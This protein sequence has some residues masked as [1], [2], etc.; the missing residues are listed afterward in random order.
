LLDG[1]DMNG[2]AVPDEKSV[3]TQVLQ[4]MNLLGQQNQQE[5]L[6][7]QL[8]KR[9][10]DSLNSKKKAEEIKRRSDDLIKWINK[11]N[12]EM[13]DRPEDIHPDDLQKKKEYKD[14]HFDHVRKPKSDEYNAIVSDAMKLRQENA[15][16]NLS[17]P[18]TGVSTLTAAWKGLMHT[19]SA[20]I[21]YIEAKLKAYQLV[22]NRE[23]AFLRKLRS[24]N[25]ASDKIAADAQEISTK[26]QT[27]D[28]SSIDPLKINQESNEQRVADT[29]EAMENL[30]KFTNEKIKTVCPS[31]RYYNERFQTPL[32]KGEAHLGEGKGKS[33]QAKNDLD[34]AEKKLDKVKENLKKNYQSIQSLQA[35]L[36]NARLLLEENPQFKQ[37]YDLEDY[38]EELDHIKFDKMKSKLDD[39][40][41]RDA[42]NTSMV[43]APVQNPYTSVKVDD[44]RNELNKLSADADNKKNSLSGERSRLEDLKKKTADLE[45]RA[46]HINKQ[47]DD[48]NDKITTV[49]DE[50][51]DDTEKAIRALEDLSTM[52]NA[53]NPAIVTLKNDAGDVPELTSQCNQLI[54][55]C[56]EAQSAVN[57][58]AHILSNKPSTDSKDMELTEEEVKSITKNFNANDT[59]ATHR[60]VPEQFKSMVVTK[61][62]LGMNTAN[63]QHEI[64]NFFMTYSSNRESLS[65]QDVL[66]GY[67]AFKASFVLKSKDSVLKMLTSKADAD[68]MI[69]EADL[70]STVSPEIFTQIQEAIGAI[71]KNGTKYYH[72]NDLV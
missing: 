57:E 10:E 15:A 48:I 1:E 8:N 70:K 28:L 67:A 53:I 31:E 41:Q 50:K 46:A 35:N 54:S 21:Q 44:L 72:I 22:A 16:K 49:N 14:N 34:E 66:K 17:P 12:E 71:E 20:N 58:Q 62:P 45:A 61:P 59:E 5:F 52:L 32:N 25:D 56:D 19:E 4:Y 39:S 26:S 6:K 51:S 60:L 2:E 3:M 47:L 38:C 36:G 33:A 7:K 64:A 29:T 42:E 68:G 23:G 69:S 65:L 24:C 27:A 37:L 40:D 43:G 9:L 30:T 18:A 11:T 13:S 55:R 63:L